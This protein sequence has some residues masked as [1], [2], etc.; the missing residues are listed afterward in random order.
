MAMKVEALTL[1][2]SQKRDIWRASDIISKQC[3]PATGNF[4]L[5]A[6]AFG[7][8]AVYNDDVVS[9]GE[10]FDVH[11]HDNMEIFTWVVEGAIKHRDSDQGLGET[12]TLS[13][14]T[15]SYINAGSGIRH[16]E[17]N[18]AG[19]SSRDFLRIIQ[20]WILPDEQD[21][22]PRYDTADVNAE[23]A[24][25]GLFLVAGP[26]GSGAKIETVSSSSR[27]HAGVLPAGGVSTLDLDQYVH[28]Y[29]VRGQAEVRVVAA[30]DEVVD[31]AAEVD[32]TPVAAEQED[33]VRITTSNVDAGGAQVQI[34][35]LE[36]DTEVLVW[37]MHDSA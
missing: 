18:A 4:D 27:L 25:G 26:T 20:M 6:G 23:I 7:R 36:P 9:P 19:Y 11:S 15:T 16:S 30:G 31:F 17:V 10:G 35:A 13:R 12:T 29:V 5:E 21:T 37:T 22:E 32:G 14:G 8:L 24:E 1:I 34:Q 28:V 3:F 2:P 33:Q